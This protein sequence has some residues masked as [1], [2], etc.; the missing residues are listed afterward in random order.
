MTIL[1]SSSTAFFFSTA[2]LG[3]AISVAPL[4]ILARRRDDAPRSVVRFGVVLLAALMLLT[5]LS[6][7]IPPLYARAILL[8]VFWALAGL[9]IA[10]QG[11]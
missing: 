8:C 10:R 1:S 9:C 6:F 3:L 4:W 2:F 5:L 7:V 11:V